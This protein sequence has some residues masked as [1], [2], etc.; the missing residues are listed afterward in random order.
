MVASDGG[1]EG[2]ASGIS[3]EGIP[4]SPVSRIAPDDRNRGEMA[5]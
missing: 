4:F 2:P 5:F 1:R 3:G